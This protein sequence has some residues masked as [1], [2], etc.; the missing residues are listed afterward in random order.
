MLLARPYGNQQTG[1]ALQREAHLVGNEG[2]EVQRPAHLVIAGCVAAVA[3]AE[4]LHGAAAGWAWAA[5]AAGLGGTLL[6]ATWRPRRALALC[7]AAGTLLLGAVLVAG[8]LTV[9]QIDCCWPA[10]REQRVTR[11]SQQLAAT[12]T[13]AVAAARRL[14]EQGALAALQPRE[15]AFT[16]LAEATRSGPHGTERGVVTLSG[17]GEPWSWAGRHRFVPAVDTA[18]LRAVITP[19]YVSLEARRQTPGGGSAVGT[20]LLDAAPAVPDRDRALSAAFADARGVGLRFLAPRSAPPGSDVFDYASR[21]GDTLFSVLTVPPSQDDA[22]LVAFTRTAQVAS[23]TLAAALLL[24]LAAAPPGAWRWVVALTGAWCLVRAPL[25]PETSLAAFFSPSTFTRPSLGPFSASAGSLTVAAALVL[26]GAGVLW[27]RGM[28]RRW[29]SLAAAAVLVVE[30]P[31]VVRN[32]GRGITPPAQGVGVA[33]W[34]S[35]EA[36]LAVATMALILLAAAL[37]RGSTEPRRTP[38]MLP[39]ACVWAGL[40]GVAGLWLWEPNNAWPEWYTFVWLPAAVGVLVP[41]PRRWSVVAIA[42]VAGTAAALITWGAA[43]EGRIALAD[44]DARRL[45]RQSDSRAAALLERMG[46]RALESSP[47]RTAGDLYSFWLGSPL[48]A[49][50]YPTVLSLWTQ[51]DEPVAELPLATLDLSPP[52]LSALVHSPETRRG[53]RVERVDAVPGVHYVLIAPLRGGEVLAVGVGPRSRLVPSS[54]VERFLHGDLPVATPYTI[55]LSLPSPTPSVVTDR[56]V[57][58]RAGWS[59][60]GERRVD[61]PGGVRH[62]HLRVDLRGPWPLLVRGVLVVTVDVALLAGCW[63][64]GVVLAEG[65]RPTL[66]PILLALRTSFRLRVAAALAAFFVL[67]VLAFALWSFARLGDEARGARDLLIRQTLKDAASSA[68]ALP[69]ERPDA[70]QRAVA[71]LGTRL[72]ADLWLYR[73][74]VLAGSSTPVLEELGLAT[75]FLAAPVFQRLAP[76]RRGGGSGSGTAS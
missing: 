15:A 50:D 16:R 64:L 12:L 7:A 43:V 55:S 38:W 44:R 11:A 23:A 51:A 59:A 25:N 24:L 61:L 17:S 37:V 40:A 31:Y 8:A 34:L 58:T 28:R 52:L 10:V 13:G 74:G 26:F 45:G 48:A 1:V 46:A 67:P 29:W 14:A 20:V 73:D 63:L 30:A 36:T 4:W 9:R 68:G 49:E 69:I 75:P 70:V 18:E 27:R 42:T 41:A 21:G 57:W 65:W 33:L 35:W 76:A 60:R 56:V 53:P 6:E 66:P 19:F 22:R 54:R 72:D 2:L 5:G 62:V 32:L 3:A 71:E 39:A 47:P